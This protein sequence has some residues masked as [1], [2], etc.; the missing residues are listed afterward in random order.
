MSS[1]QSVTERYVS[2]LIHYGRNKEFSIV[3]ITEQESIHN[4]IVVGNFYSVSIRPALEP[5]TKSSYGA[6]IARAVRHCL[7]DYGVTFR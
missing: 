4:G 7:E 6:T 1:P 3:A 5:T 2:N